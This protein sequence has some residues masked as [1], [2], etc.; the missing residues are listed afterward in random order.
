MTFVTKKMFFLMKASLT[1][2]KSS[3]ILPLGL[4]PVVEKFMCSDAVQRDL[5]NIFGTIPVQY[6]VTMEMYKNNT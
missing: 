2:F 3:S 5:V 4:L 1:K 6:K